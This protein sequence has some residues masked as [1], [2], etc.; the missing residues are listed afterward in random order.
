[1]TYFIY[2]VIAAIAYLVHFETLACGSFPLA[3]LSCFCQMSFKRI[4]F[5]T[6]RTIPTSII[7]NSTAEP[8]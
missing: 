2:M 8:P 7:R 4:P 3:P 1:M 5:A 6:L